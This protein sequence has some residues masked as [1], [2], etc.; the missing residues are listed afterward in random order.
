MRLRS[1]PT[2]AAGAVFIRTR[3]A[4][5]YRQCH[6]YAVENVCNWMIPADSPDRCAA[7]A[8]LSHTIPNLTAPDNRVYWYRLEIGERRLL[9]TLAALGCTSTRASRIRRT[10]SSSSSSKTAATASG[11]DRP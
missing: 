5:L 2:R 7:P 3:T 4:R 8:S 11:H 6:N 9:Y 10:A 1:R